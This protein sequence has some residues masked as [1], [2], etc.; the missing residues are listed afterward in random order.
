MLTSINSSSL[1]DVSLGTLDLISNTSKKVGNLSGRVVSKFAGIANSAMNIS[2]F[3]RPYIVNLSNRAVA[4]SLGVMALSCIPLAGAANGSAACEWGTSGSVNKSSII[5]PFPGPDSPVFG[6]AKVISDLLA[7]GGVGALLLTHA[8]SLL[9]NIYMNHQENNTESKSKMEL[10]RTE[11]DK[12]LKSSIIVFSGIGLFEE[13]K[14]LFHKPRPYTYSPGYIN[15]ELCLKPDDFKSFPSGHACMGAYLWQE[16][17][18]QWIDI[19]STLSPDI[20]AKLDEV[21]I[22]KSP[23]LTPDGKQ[24]MALMISALSGSLTGLMRVLAAKHD[25]L[26]IFIGTVLGMVSSYVSHKVQSGVLDSTSVINPRTR[27][28]YNREA[29][30]E[31]EGQFRLE[32]LGQLNNQLEE[33]EA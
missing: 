7:Y 29:L 10:A 15:G 31:P 26:D 9:A 6:G 33:A 3:S 17:F 5:P 2:S 4:L 30:P 22:F 27:H 32:Q 21:K 12:L 20:R 14:L 18:I 24:K 19:L 8:T 11:A 16:V 23:I 13:T 1:S 25:T 28:Y